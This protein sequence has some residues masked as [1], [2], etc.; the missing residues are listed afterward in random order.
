MC[1]V[2][3]VALPP[4][5][6]P[7]NQTATEVTRAAPAAPATAPEESAPIKVPPGDPAFWRFN[8][9]DPVA[10]GSRTS[11][12]FER[13][14]FKRCAGRLL[15]VQ[16]H[17]SSVGACKGMRQQHHLRESNYGCHMDTSSNGKCVTARQGL[18]YAL[19]PIVLSPLTCQPVLLYPPL[20]P[21]LLRLLLPG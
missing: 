12:P 11:L 19:L 14:G 1:L 16:V 6:S 10:Q 5:F 3:P 2:T 13:S 17:V 9:S 20:V 4:H 7:C 15:H 8:G 18:M 21:M